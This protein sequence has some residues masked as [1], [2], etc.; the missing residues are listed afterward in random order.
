M[1]LDVKELLSKFLD[2]WEDW[3]TNNTVDT[4]IPVFINGKIQHRVL[5][6][7]LVKAQLVSANIN[8]AYGNYVSVT[9]PSVSGYKFLCWAQVACTGWVGSV[10]PSAPLSTTCNMWNATTGQ[11]GTGQIACLALYIPVN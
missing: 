10:Y 2:M 3:Q 9:A 6:R 4:W 7:D 5:P 11:S 1:K 8:K